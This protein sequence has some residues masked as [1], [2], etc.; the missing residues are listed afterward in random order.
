MEGKADRYPKP[1]RIFK[2]HLLTRSIQTTQ[3]LFGIRESNPL[4]HMVACMNGH[5]RPIVLYP[6]Q[7]LTIFLGRSDT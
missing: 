5:A 3:S 4:D 7:K 2:K 6:K 1:V